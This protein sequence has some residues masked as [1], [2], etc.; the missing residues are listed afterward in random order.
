MVTSLSGLIAISSLYSAHYNT[1]VSTLIH[2]AVTAALFWFKELFDKSPETFRGAPSPSCLAPQKLKGRLFNETRLVEFPCTAPMF[3][4]VEA[5]FN[6]SVGL[7]KCSATGEPPPVLYWVQPSGKIS[8][9]E[10]P[11]D[12]DVL[13][14][15]G[16]LIVDS[17]NPEV[18]LNGMFICTSQL[19]QRETLRFTLN[20][21][22]GPSIR[23]RNSFISSSHAVVP[24]NS[25]KI[26]NIA[27]GSGN[28][29]TLFDDISDRATP[30]LKIDDSIEVVTMS[31]VG[32]NK[33]LKVTEPSRY[34]WSERTFTLSELVGAAVA[35]HIGTILVY[36]LVVAGCYW[37]RCKARRQ[38]RRIHQR[39]AFF[40]N[41]KSTLSPCSALLPE[42]V[43]LNG[44][45]HRYVSTR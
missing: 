33:S 40:L 42:T 23:S 21:P 4:R 27:E 35:T 9:Y 7:L 29:K 24:V 25:D 15:E 45:D 30:L 17:E 20:L 2:C 34:Y 44:L 14:N 19:I 28:A 8:M 36:V 38:I 37:T 5:V 16:D 22:F 3:I 11:S 26:S 43:C 18:R 41:N 6:G 31:A 13:N 12:N 10:I 39:N 1:S 32:D